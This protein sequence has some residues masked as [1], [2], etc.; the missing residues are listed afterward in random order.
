MF[1]SYRLSLLATGMLGHES[2]FSV[3]HNFSLEITGPNLAFLA[4]RIRGNR[5]QAQSGLTPVITASQPAGPF[6]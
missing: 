5:S 1:V 2:S 4:K 6:T 3:Q